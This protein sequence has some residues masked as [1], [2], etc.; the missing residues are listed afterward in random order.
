MN[1]ILF[2][3]FKLQI[4][5]DW[6]V[7][8]TYDFVSSLPNCSQ[9]GDILKEQV[10]DGDALLLLSKTDFIGMMD[11]GSMTWM[12]LYYAL[13]VIK[14]KEVKL[15][16]RHLSMTKAL[17]KTNMTTSRMIVEQ[18]QI[19]TIQPQQEEDK[20]EE[21]TTIDDDVDDGIDDD[22]DPDYNYDEA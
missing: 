15:K 21:L 16:G 11:G 4:V 17:S 3:F 9:L 10:V 13:S 8:Q 7:D 19:Q 14:S 5:R 22:V 1:F 6:N 12:K 2:Y 18:I 20:E